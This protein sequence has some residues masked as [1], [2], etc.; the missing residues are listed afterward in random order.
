MYERFA[1]PDEAPVATRDRMIRW[2]QELSRTIDYLETRP[3]FDARKIA[4][5]GF[6]LGGADGP[7]FT[8]VEPRFA[9]SILLAGGLIP[10]RFRPEVDPARFAPRVRTPTLMINGRDDFILPYELSQQPM[11]D[12]LGVPAAHKRHA[13]LDGGHI[14]S[15]R[16]EIMREVLDWLDR[17]L[18]P[19][20]RR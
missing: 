20:Q 11:F 15:D 3:D 16:R 6:S 14:P 13:R 19:V 1:P 17:Y 4:F 12:L 9:A 8:G 2:T 18:G 10:A 7:L 5:Y